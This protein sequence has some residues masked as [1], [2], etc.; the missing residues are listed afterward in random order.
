MSIDDPVE[1]F[2]SIP[3]AHQPRVSPDDEWV[4]CI[5]SDSGRFELHAIHLAAGERRQLTDGDLP[6]DPEDTLHHW[7]G[8]SDAVI[9]QGPERDGTTTV[10]RAPL[11]G[12]VEELFT[13]DDSILV[14]AVDP[15]S[16]RI[17]YRVGDDTL[18]W[19]DPATGETGE[20]PRFPWFP[21]ETPSFCT[22]SPGGERIAYTSLPPDA[23][24]GSTTYEWGLATYVARADGSD[25]ARVNPR[26]GGTR[27]MP[28]QWHPDGER[29]LVNSDSGSWQDEREC[30]LYDVC[31]GTVEWIADAGAVAFLDSERIL[32]GAMPRRLVEIYD[33]EGNATA[34]DC[35]GLFHLIN[36]SD[37]VVGDSG[38][39]F[40]RKPENR[41][42][43]ARYHDIATGETTTLF[44]AGYEDRDVGPETF[45]NP[46]ETTYET[47]D[48]EEAGGLLYW[49]PDMGT[50]PVPAVV[51]LYGGRS[52]QGTFRPVA[53]LLAYLG[54]TVFF[55]NDPGEAWRWEEDDAF[56]AAGRWIAQQEGI[57]GD[58]VGCYGHSHGGYNV[59]MQAVRYP[60]VWDAFVADTGIVDASDHPPPRA[61]RRLGS[62]GENADVY[63]E[64][65]PIEH[66]GDDPGQPLLMVH[67]ENDRHADHPRRFAAE[68]D[69]LGWSD[70]EEYES[71]ELSGMKHHLQSPDEKIRKWRSITDFLDR[72]L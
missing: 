20:I 29:L 58:R 15:T 24:N 22:V 36:G 70:G 37:V 12:P 28:I 17:Y 43:E 38:F 30:G 1:A 13:V 72:R 71:V 55:P 66:L 11:D 46:V 49:P 69:D 42:F 3:E 6:A 48:G 14:W 25:P 7:V 27:I 2:Q 31:D 59:Y 39:V 8:E 32:A 67:A 65:S 60:E 45:V 62:P 53:Q 56:A 63:R 16:G 40:I 23:D 21:L 19:R 26:D 61:V 51:H 47:H 44:G 68:L 5:W 4:A 10:Y 64:L 34:V 9:F 33:L 18:Q 52:V 35:E 41:H 50:D 54:Y 57:D